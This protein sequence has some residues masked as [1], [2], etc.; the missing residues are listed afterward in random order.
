MLITF[1]NPKMTASPSDTSIRTRM[2]LEESRRKIRMRS[3]QSSMYDAR[4]ARVTSLDAMDAASTPW[5]TKTARSA[6]AGEVG[7]LLDQQN[8]QVHGSG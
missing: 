6:T 7:I 2:A 8:G 3:I 5:S 1:I 4:I